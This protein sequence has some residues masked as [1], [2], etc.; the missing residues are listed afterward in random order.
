MQPIKEED[1]YNMNIILCK[2]KINPNHFYNVIKK[3]NVTDRKTEYQLL[4][5]FINLSDKDIE[6]LAV[7]IRQLKG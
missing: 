3:L 2:S 5:T 1:I 7:E 4:R 6:R